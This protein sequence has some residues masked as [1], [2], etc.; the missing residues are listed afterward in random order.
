MERGRRRLEHV[1]PCENKGHWPIVKWSRAKNN[2]RP[3]LLE[4]AKVQQQHWQALT[5]HLSWPPKNTFA[6]AIF[7]ALCILAGTEPTR[8]LACFY[9]NA[10]AQN[11]C[12]E[13]T[14]LPAL[15]GLKATGLACFLLVLFMQ[16]GWAGELKQLNTLQNCNKKCLYCLEYF[17][18]ASARRC[19]QGQIFAFFFF[20]LEVSI[21]FY[22]WHW[23]Q[24]QA[25]L[26]SIGLSYIFYNQ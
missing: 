20:G 24:C 1:W 14:L 17:G 4:K 16:K 19:I 7:H 25:A 6:Q 11:F 3:A 15:A 18:T 21:L 12:M 5:H 22:N 2:L 9:G 10:A 26:L 23:C 8:A 13:E